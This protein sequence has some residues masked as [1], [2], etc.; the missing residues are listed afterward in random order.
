M[1]LCSDVRKLITAGAFLL[2]RF[3]MACGTFSMYWVLNV[4]MGCKDFEERGSTPPP[5]SI[6][7]SENF[8]SGGLCWT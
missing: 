1:E 6:C 7:A 4:W 3:L 8:S 2:G 5:R